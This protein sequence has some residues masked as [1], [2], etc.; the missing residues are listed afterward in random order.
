MHTRWLPYAVT[1]IDRSACTCTYSLLVHSTNQTG[2]LTATTRDSPT[3]C[4]LLQTV[5]IQ[6]LNHAVHCTQV[7]SVYHKVAGGL[8]MCFPLTCA[9]NHKRSSTH[10]PSSQ[11]WAS[12]CPIHFVF[13]Y[14]LFVFY[15]CSLLGLFSL[16]SSLPL[17]LP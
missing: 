9:C 4:L 8:P 12:K 11:G 16:L 7:P 10:C 13:V 15:G 3:G 6:Y 2:A 17:R 5:L 14:F 1:T